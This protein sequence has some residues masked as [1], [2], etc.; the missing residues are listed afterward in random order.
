V[1]EKLNMPIKYGYFPTTNG[2]CLKLFG[3]LLL[4]NPLKMQIWKEKN[5]QSLLFLKNNLNISGV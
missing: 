5:D 2:I 3:T 4:S 1:G